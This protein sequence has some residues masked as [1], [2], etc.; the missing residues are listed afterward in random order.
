M[1]V[2]TVTQ[3]W[4]F[5]LPRKQQIC[6]FQAHSRDFWLHICVFTQGTDRMLNIYDEGT[7]LR[8]TGG[9]TA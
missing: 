8:G 6:L 1:K 5:L 3:S 7:L 4:D 2:S 9:L